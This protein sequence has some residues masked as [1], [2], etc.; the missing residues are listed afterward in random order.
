MNKEILINVGNADTRV[1]LVEDDSLV[2]FYLE[3]RNPEGIAGNIYRGRISS[4]LPG[5]QAAFVDIGLDRNA[6]LY[7]DDINAGF[8][9]DE[10][11]VY[12]GTGFI[13]GNRDFAIE[14]VLKAGQE[15][16][17]QVIKEPIGTKGPRLTTSI[18]LPGRYLVFMPG[19]DY[20]G[21]SR[22]I[23]DERE[24][25]FL[26]NSLERIKPEGTGLI[27]RTAAE[28]K[29][30]ADLER[31]LQFL[32]KLWENIR[33]REHSGPVPRCIHKDFN[34]VYR[35]V[36]DLFS[37]DIN[38]F[39]VNDR[40]QYEKVIDLV[41]MMSPSLKERVEYVADQY[42]IF[43]RHDINSE[44]AKALCRKVW[45][46]S[47]GYIVIDKSEALYVID[48]N[49]GKY[50]GKSS[51]EETIFRTNL[52]AAKEIAKQLRLRDIGGIIIIDFIDMKESEHRHAVSHALKSELKKD[53]TKTVVVGMTGLGLIEM[54][55]K[56]VRQELYS[57]LTTECPRCGGSGR[58]IRENGTAISV[59]DNR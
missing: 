29:T 48:V 36:R 9:E 30:V 31:E 58:L 44:L 51:F 41:E 52:E 6:F 35:S 42:D 55:R 16:T 8:S 10:D 21:I 24:R 26:K 59:V 45:L 33:Q 49:T 18:T 19:A 20:T 39:V 13:A 38:R 47:G 56:K 53:R 1:A 54:T 40:Q 50:V 28:G 2:E 27:A 22:R 34:L 4:V 23:E 12:D 3:K 25:A 43:E 57:A 46:K 7:V 32:A 17:V 11:D 14:D 5:I 37:W 15:I